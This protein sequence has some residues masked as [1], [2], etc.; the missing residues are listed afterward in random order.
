MLFLDHYGAANDALV[1]ARATLPTVRQG[2]ERK[3][4]VLYDCWVCNWRTG[5][6]VVGPVGCSGLWYEEF[7]LLTPPRFITLSHLLFAGVNSVLTPEPRQ[8]CGTELPRATLKSQVYPSTRRSPQKQVLC[9][10]SRNAPSS[11][12]RR[13]LSRRPSLPTCQTNYSLSGIFLRS[14]M[15]LE[16]ELSTTQ[17]SVPSLVTSSFHP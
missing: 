1:A 12:G 11:R 9:P 4:V 3:S 10:G 15:P 13:S 16:L 17:R 8:G 14:K 5:M 2:L 6:S 7:G